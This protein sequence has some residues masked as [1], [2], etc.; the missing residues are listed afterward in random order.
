MDERAAF[1]NAPPPGWYQDPFAGDPEWE[2]FRRRL[3]ERTVYIDCEALT[4]TLGPEARFLFRPGEPV[5]GPAGA[6]AWPAVRCQRPMSDATIRRF[7]EEHVAHIA[8]GIRR[9]RYRQLL[10]RPPRVVAVRSFPP[11]TL[12]ARWPRLGISD[13]EEVV[14]AV[15]ACY[16]EPAPFMIA[17]GGVDYLLLPYNRLVPTLKQYIGVWGPSVSIVREIVGDPSLPASLDW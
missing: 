3:R 17:H 12:R 4:T 15:I 2:D 11:G 14:L 7:A 16:C 6:R 5:T 10:D 1:S 8:D 9:G 13:G